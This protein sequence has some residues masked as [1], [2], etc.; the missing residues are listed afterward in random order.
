M[1][2]NKGIPWWSSVKTPP[3]NAGDPGSTPSLGTKI[4]HATGQLSLC[5]TITE[6]RVRESWY[7]FEPLSFLKGK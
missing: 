4:P 5:P 2:K 7:M 6:A 1:K 3:A